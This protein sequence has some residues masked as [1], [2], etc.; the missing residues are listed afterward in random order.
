[1]SKIIK[2]IKYKKLDLVVSLESILLLNDIVLL[3]GKERVVRRVRRYTYPHQ[4]DRVASPSHAV[5]PCSTSSLIVE[6]CA[7]LCSLILII[8]LCLFTGLSNIAIVFT[9]ACLLDFDHLIIM[10][11]NRRE[12]CVICD[13]S[14]L[15]QRQRHLITH[16][17]I[18]SRPFVEEYIQSQS[19]REVS[20]VSLCYAYDK[21]LRRNHTKSI[22]TA[23]VPSTMYLITM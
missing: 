4:V 20:C 23:T 17:L 12:L 22:N 18:Q 14:V 7:F 11:G 10:E 13:R 1:M 19:S 9:C 6:Y 15:R 8:D 3:C 2:N 21:S 16:T 5:T